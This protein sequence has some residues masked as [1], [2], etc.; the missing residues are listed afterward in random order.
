MTSG[1]SVWNRKSLPD[2]KVYRIL[3]PPGFEANLCKHEYEFQ[4]TLGQGNFGSV[5]RAVHR[6]TGK[7]VAIKVLN[8]NDFAQKPKM[9]KAMIQEVSIIVEWIHQDLSIYFL[10]VINT[11]LGECH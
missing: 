4:H 11:A 1:S 3:L 6:V 2:N 10:L 5:K 8:K 9:F 7:T